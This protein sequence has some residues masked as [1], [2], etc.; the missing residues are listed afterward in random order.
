MAGALGCPLILLPGVGHIASL[1][2]PEL[3]TDH[4]LAFLRRAGLSDPG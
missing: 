3:V 4:L 1:E 2:A